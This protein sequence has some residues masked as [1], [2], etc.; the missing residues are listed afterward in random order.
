MSNGTPVQEISAEQDNGR[1][2]PIVW[3]ISAVVLLA[4]LMTSLDTTVVNVSLAT[5]S[6]ELHTPLTTIQWVTSGYLLALTLTL[7]LSGWLVDRVGTKRVY[8]ICFAA[9]V[10]S[11]ML[12]GLATS[13]EAL[14]GFR[15]LQGMTGGLLAPLAQMMIASI[16]GRH[17]ARVMGLAVMPVLIGP[18]L[19]PV[20]AGAILQSAG[21]R[22]IFFINL[23]IGIF[24][25][26]LAQWLLPGDD[27]EA[28]PRALDLKGL[29]LLSPGL[30]LLLH[31]LENLSSNPNLKL[32][33]ELELLASLGFLCAF[34][35]HAVRR[36]R[37]SLI[38]VQLFRHPAFSSGAITQ[39]LSNAASFG[40]AML[41]PL[42]LLTMQNASPGSVGL[43]LAPSGLGML[44][45]YPT[46]GW[47]T[48]RFGPRAVSATGALVA[49]FGTLP[50]A[51][52]GASGLS[53]TLICAALFVRGLGQGAI[54]IPSIASAYATI[55]KQNIPM[56]TTA[57]NIV[58][59]L[60]GPAATT[61]L[62]IFLH[63]RQLVSSSAHAF[64]AT[65]WL[66]CVLQILT[67]V[68]ALCLP[69][70]ITNRQN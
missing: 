66:L 57:L 18:I 43:L 54:G 5:L 16:A 31:S 1:I 47:V 52:Y 46:M 44:L 39:F 21:W 19:G 40:G 68:S 50:F 32:L 33:S 59:R 15:V 61:L 7:P 12:C 70:R 63:S 29:F 64:A 30:V 45:S 24:A 23:P 8:L 17:V 62:A 53:V 27:R 48:E 6:R 56:A 9:F 37:K 13:A 22:W 51:L 26:I 14:I 20:L 42:Y 25:I 36:G 58:Q 35:V 11:S 38:D 10:L 3:K 55:P 4:P 34:I 69:Q 65:F 28:H 67:V 41:T 2:D 49:L 60:G